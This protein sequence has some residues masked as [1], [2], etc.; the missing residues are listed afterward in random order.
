MLEEIRYRGPDN[1]NSIS[2]NFFDIGAVRLSIQDLSDNGNQPFFS[3]DRNIITIYNGEIYNYKELKE[4]I[5]KIII[6]KVLV[7][8]KL[9]LTCIKN[10]V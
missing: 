1:K 10:L 3:R 4:N 8:A 5:L 7:M 9:F 6:L 2:G